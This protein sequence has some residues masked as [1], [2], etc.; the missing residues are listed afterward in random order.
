MGFK[1][2]WSKLNL[3]CETN[4]PN[5][6][7]RLADLTSITWLWVTSMF[8]IA[9]KLDNSPSSLCSQEFK[10]WH[11]ITISSKKTQSFFLQISVHFPGHFIAT[12]E[13]WA[14]P[15][16]CAGCWW[17][18]R[19]R[20]S[21]SWASSTA[22][23]PSPPRPSPATSFNPSVCPVWSHLAWLTKH[24]SASFNPDEMF[25]VPPN[26]DKPSS[27]KNGIVPTS[28]CPA[29]FVKQ[30]FSLPLSN[31]AAACLLGLSQ[32]LC[33]FCAQLSLRTIGKPCRN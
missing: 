20:A 27:R 3:I 28:S 12:N 9:E 30:A 13:R 18:R 26:A 6:I 15:V 4:W 1:T 19:C 25:E 10:A 29:G 14:S 2:P 22:P 24:Q 23:S 7:Q 32:L 31:W 17:W 11:E 5:F 33:R 21:T 16:R 8:P